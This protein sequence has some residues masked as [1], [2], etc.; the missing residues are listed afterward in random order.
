LYVEI[1]WDYKPIAPK[2]K[3]AQR[4]P[5]RR[6]VFRVRSCLCHAEKKIFMWNEN[7]Q[8]NATPHSAV[9]SDQQ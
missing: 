8:E 3:R 7:V 1:A 2:V 5:A 4:F 9:T 6:I